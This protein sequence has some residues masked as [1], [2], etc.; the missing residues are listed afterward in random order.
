[1][2]KDKRVNIT[3]LIDV[4]IPY[5]T[6]IKDKQIEKIQKYQDLKIQVQRCW[7]TTVKVIPIVMGALGA[8]PPELQQYLKTIGCDKL[9]IGT[10]QK[11]VLLGT[12]HIIRKV[13]GA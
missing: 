5:D 1:M 6:R 12:A 3:F 10:I 2:L 7:D 4:A 11:S 13:L 8:Q 9:Y